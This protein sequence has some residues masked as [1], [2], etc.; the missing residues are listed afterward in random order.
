MTSKETEQTEP[1]HN[2]QKLSTDQLL[3]LNKKFSNLK[4]FQE[5]MSRI[6]ALDTTTQ[7]GEDVSFVGVESPSDYLQTLY[8]RQRLLQVHMP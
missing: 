5:A 7:L 4:Q 8:D 1:N 3:K 6:P 2:H